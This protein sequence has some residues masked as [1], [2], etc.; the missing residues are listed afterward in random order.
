MA[1]TL[2]VCLVPFGLTNTPPTFIIFMNTLLYKNLGK[3][4]LVFVDGILIYYAIVEEYKI[5]HWQIFDIVRFS[6][7][8]QVKQ[9]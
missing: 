7:L 1:R 2:R 9:A 4:I 3:F 6:K 5:H 8:S